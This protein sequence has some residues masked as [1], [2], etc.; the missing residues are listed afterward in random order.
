MANDEFIGRR[1]TVGLGLESV[2]GTPAAPAFYMRRT[3]FGL[4]R[5]TTR[6]E[7]DSAMGRVEKVNDSAIV[8]RWAEGSIEG[9]VYDTSVGPL[10]YNIFGSLATSDNADSNPVV[11]DHTFNV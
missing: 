11:K 6:I 10:L 4:Q 9:K 3:A 5:K 1:V 8:E 2:S 7:N